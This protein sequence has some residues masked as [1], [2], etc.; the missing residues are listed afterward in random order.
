MTW[1][2]RG[3]ISHPWQQIYGKERNML[4]VRKDRWEGK[5][6]GAQGDAGT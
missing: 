4:W 3:C 2:Q 6:I 1:F 5:G